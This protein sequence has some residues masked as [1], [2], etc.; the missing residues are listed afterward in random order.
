LIG[1]EVNQRVGGEREHPIAGEQA[2]HRGRGKTYRGD[3]QQALKNED[4]AQIRPA[5]R[6]FQHRGQPSAIDLMVSRQLGFER[7]TVTEQ[8]AGGQFLHQ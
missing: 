7:Q 4:R 8:G 5:D 2:E 3:G 6:V 1:H